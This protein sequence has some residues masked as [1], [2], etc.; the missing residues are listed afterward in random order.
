[1]G[2]AALD[3]PGELADSWRS[4]STADCLS[5]PTPLAVL[6][7]KSLLSI[8]PL[9]LFASSAQAQYLGSPFSYNYAEL[10]YAGMDVRGVDGKPDG[11]GG[12]VSFEVADKVRFLGSWT[13]VEA[14]VNGVVNRRQ[15]ME[16][17]FGFSS[18]VN[19]QTEMV[20][21]L[22]YLRSEM[23]QGAGVPRDES[24]YGIELGTR[25]LI[26]D[27]VEFDISAEWRE[28]YTSEYG[29]HAQL[30]VNFGPHIALTGSYSYFE[31]QQWYVGGLRLSM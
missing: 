10:Y 23:K 18:S 12:L 6:R 16:A 9:A 4:A 15:D 17:G 13:E 5:T 27:W 30:I 29:G 28:L 31:S 22:K 8:V 7:A 2:G 1:M 21:D 25:S 26:N 14:N 11:P 3:L 20:L 24:G 19:S